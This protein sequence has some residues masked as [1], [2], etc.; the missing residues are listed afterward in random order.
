LLERKGEK[1]QDGPE[2]SA[3]ED[4]DLTD[5][6]EQDL[7]EEAGEWSSASEQESDDEGRTETAQE[8]KAAAVQVA[9]GPDARKR[10]RKSREEDDDLEA[11]YLAQ[12]QD[13]DEPAGKR[14]KDASGEKVIALSE[15]HTEGRSAAEVEDGESLSGEDLVH[16]SLKV[17]SAQSEVD[18]ANRTA[19]LSNVSVEAVTSAKAKKTLLAHLSSVLDK[20][21]T[22]PQAIESIRFRSTAFAS[23]GLPKRAAYAQKSVMDATTKSTNAY[24][25]YN[26]S[27]AVRTAVNKLNGSVILDRHL[28][29]D[30]V[31]HP[32]AQDHKRCV[33][34][35]NLG[36]VNDET[37]INTKMDEEGK[38]VT[39]KRKRTRQPMDV[40]EGLWRVFNKEAGKV[41]SVRVVRDAA[42]RVG[43]G[44][45][46]V[47]F[48]VS[49]LPVVL[50]P[51]DTANLVPG[52]KRR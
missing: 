43:K 31:A 27:K 45:A 13:D 18:K 16:E 28:R 9:P 33:F 47:Q 2:E 26:S 44:I 8:P 50:S 36:F 49:P 48:Y 37:V 12:L 41:E 20:T 42:T 1:N 11:R 51:K 34:V 6:D 32:A 19:F 15:T 10:K 4:N 17:D 46:Y 25:V 22:P 3:E 52:C 29:V 39:E 5:G 35:G 7:E 30:S 14:L 40:E 24:V 21:T 23:A 38:E